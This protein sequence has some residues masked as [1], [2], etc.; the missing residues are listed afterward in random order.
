MIRD[1]HDLAGPV[2]FS[3]KEALIC[4][5][6]AAEEMDRRYDALLQEGFTKLSDRFVSGKK[7]IPFRVLVFDEF[8]DLVHSG[9]EG[10]KEFERLVVRIAGK[11]RAAGIHLVVATS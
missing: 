7:D 1:N 9:K 11:G 3:L 4:L 5:A 8:A 2:I 6:D 10:K